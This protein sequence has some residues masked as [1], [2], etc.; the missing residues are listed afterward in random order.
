MMDI[1][2]CTPKYWIENTDACKNDLKNNWNSVKKILNFNLVDL[3]LL[4][5]VK[6]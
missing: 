1:T 2:K 5:E 6:L 4:N 3:R